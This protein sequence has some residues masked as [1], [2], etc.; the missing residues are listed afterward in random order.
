[1]LGMRAR[2]NGPSIPEGTS[3]EAPVSDQVYCNKPRAR[4]L[5]LFGLFPAAGESFAAHK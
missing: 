5:F 2:T 3:T 1:M 4:S